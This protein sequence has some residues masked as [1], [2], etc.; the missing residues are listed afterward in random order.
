MNSRF[1]KKKK[2]KKSILIL[3]RFSSQVNVSSF[4]DVLIFLLENETK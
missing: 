4:K 3:H 1:L 2:K